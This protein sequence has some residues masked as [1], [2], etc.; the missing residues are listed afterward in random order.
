[1]SYIDNVNK[2]PS[3]FDDGNDASVYYNE[4]NPI[5]SSQQEYTEYEDSL[6][7]NTDKKKAVS[8]TTTT[9]TTKIKHNANRKKMNGNNYYDSSQSKLTEFTEPVVA[10]SQIFYHYNDAKDWQLLDTDLRPHRRTLINQFSLWCLLAAF[11]EFLPFC[12]TIVVFSIWGIS[13]ESIINL[14]FFIHVFKSM[15]I[16]MKVFVSTDI[17]K[18]YGRI[19]YHWLWGIWSRTSH[20]RGDK[21]LVM[22][23]IIYGY[24]HIPMML[25]FLLIAAGSYPLF[26]SSIAYWITWP[27]AIVSICVGY[28][29]WCIIISES[30]IRKPLERYV[31][32][33]RKD[34]ER[35]RE[36]MI[37]E[38]PKVL[39]YSR[40]VTAAPF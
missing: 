26:T 31:D 16:L 22:Y 24:I 12:W 28:V 3:P 30:G 13:Y 39:R 2:Y 37:R 36:R 18:Y 6:L 23:S 25:L 40:E 10:P 8:A 15:L 19:S 32:F 7:F 5:L 29:T 9:T 20:V 17:Y 33:T 38:T 4:Y 35:T 11:I 34:R 14:V 1:M 21:T 27:M